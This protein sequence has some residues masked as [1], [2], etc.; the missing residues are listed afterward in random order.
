[1]IYL[2]RSDKLQFGGGL[3]KNDIIEN[4]VLNAYNNLI[5]LAKNK[6][7]I[8]GG[9]FGLIIPKSKLSDLIN[10]V[11]EII[12]KLFFMFC[13]NISNN[14]TVSDM[15]FIKYK[16][17][18]FNK[19]SDEL[20]KDCL[21]IVN[22]HIKKSSLETTLIEDLN[23]LKPKYSEIEIR[24]SLDTIFDILLDYYSLIKN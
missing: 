22:N 21:N 11:D 14:L 7:Y 18:C 1:M 5:N 24:K 13:K 6:E 17:F 12:C 9:Y 16:S 23:S 3:M 8:A 10:Y 2:S 19:P 15:K 4:V 20:I